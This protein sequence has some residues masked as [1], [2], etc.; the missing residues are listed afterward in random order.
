MKW[1]FAGLCVLLCL[2]ADPVQM[3]QTPFDPVAN[4]AHVGVHS[5]QGQRDQPQVP[6]IQSNAKHRNPHSL[7][8]FDLRS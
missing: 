2:S 3:M 5:Y 1:I 7:R 4:Y 8:L 6:S